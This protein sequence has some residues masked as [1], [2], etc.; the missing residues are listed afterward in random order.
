[1][2]DSLVL[3][4]I[5]VQIDLRSAHVGVRRHG[6]PHIARGKLREAHNQLATA[7]SLKMDQLDDL[8]LICRRLI[9]EPGAFQFDI[10]NDMGWISVMRRIAQQVK[11]G[12]IMR[13]GALKADIL[14]ATSDVKSIQMRQIESHLVHRDYPGSAN[15][16]DT[17][18][19]AVP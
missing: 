13:I 17:L 18:T 3:R 12:R 8:S 11:F 19:L 14:I 9:A 1:M 10:A 2:N 15:I 7:N 5:K 6:V 4:K 16:E